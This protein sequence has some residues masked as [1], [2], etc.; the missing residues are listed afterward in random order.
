ME[1]NYQIQH[2]CEN[3]SDGRRTKYV[4]KKQQTEPKRN[5]TNKSA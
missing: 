1:H 5:T 4:L 3:N 2:A